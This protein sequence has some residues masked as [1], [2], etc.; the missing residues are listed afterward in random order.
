MTSVIRLVSTISLHLTLTLTLT[1]V[2][3]PALALQAGAHIYSLEKQQEVTLAQLLEDLQQVRTIFIGELHDRESHHRAQLQIIRELHEAG[4]VLSIGLE[5]FRADG[6]ADL[7]RWFEGKIDE[8]AFAAVFEDH[9]SLWPQYRE[10]FR[11]AQDKGIPMV[12]L[13]IPRELV[14]QVAR[15]GFASLSPEQRAQLPIAG[16]N[17]HPAYRDF[18]RRA[19]SGFDGHSDNGAEFE[20]FCEAQ[21][22]WDASMAQHL[23]EYLQRN[24]Q[25]VVVVLAGNGH[26][27]R[28][29]IPEQLS[30]LGSYSHRVLL[31]E[32]HG[33]TDLNTLGPKDADYL[34]QGLEEGPLH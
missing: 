19:F 16:C 32:T 18:I 4:V 26:S 5:M 33:R 7:D 28:H 21:M 8:P 6:Q 15:K 9:W 29:G 3:A 1:L 10:I 25:R 12:G 23:H 30:L 24:P 11:F 31:P 22:L 20:H 17:V 2:L 27:W 14:N 13:N 34:L